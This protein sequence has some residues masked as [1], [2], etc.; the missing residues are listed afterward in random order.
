MEK[1]SLFRE[2]LEQVK[3]TARLQKNCITEEQVEEI[4]EEMPLEKEQMAMVYEYLTSNHI[5]IGDEEKE[6][7]LDETDTSYL[8]MYLEEL[9]ELAS[10]TD[11]EKQVITISAMAGDRDAKDKL[12]QLFL[13]QVLEIAKLYTGQGVFLED[14]IGEGNVALTI[15]VEMLE[16][17]E[18][19]AEAEGMLGRMI[20]EAMEEYISIY[21]A[22]KDAEKKALEKVNMIQEKA[23]ELAEDLQRKVTVEELAAEMGESEEDIL[24]IIRISAENIEYIEDNKYGN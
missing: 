7:L 3:Q 19:E 5:A 11:L 22:Q 20:M 13:P 8:N 1:E 9:R 14:L 23:K 2:L 10:V 15:G 21:A 18:A 4:F 12:I 17:L 16:C 6:T 24:E